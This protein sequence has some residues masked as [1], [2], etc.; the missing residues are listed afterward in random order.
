MYCYNKYAP[1]QVVCADITQALSVTV[2][3]NII[4]V[5]NIRQYDA[6]NH[7]RHK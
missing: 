7:Y 5:M 6:P 4:Y 2:T 3:F 1:T